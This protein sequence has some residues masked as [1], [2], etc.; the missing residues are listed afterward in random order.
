MGRWSKGIR[1]R[2]LWRD[3]GSHA[4]MLWFAATAPPA[5]MS[6]SAAF[7]QYGGP[8]KEYFGVLWVSKSLEASF[9]GIASN[10][11]SVERY[12]HNRCLREGRG[13]PEYKKDCKRGVWVHNGFMAFAMDKTRAWGTGWD[14]TRAAASSLAKRICRKHGGTRAATS[15]RRLGRVTTPQ[16]SQHRVVRNNSK[17]TS[18]RVM[19]LGE[20]RIEIRISRSTWFPRGP[21][22]P[23]S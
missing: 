14:H 4:V 12:A 1:R 16:I 10:R 15:T 9:P 18:K 5:T 21:H 2:R 11:S 17:G 6:S 23:H 3:T 19:N 8:D 22:F 13:N 20:N 7:A